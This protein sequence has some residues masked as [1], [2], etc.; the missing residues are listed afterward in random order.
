MNH[1]LWVAVVG[2]DSV[3]KFE[4]SLWQGYG[5]CHLFVQKVDFCPNRSCMGVVRLG[6]QIQ[7]DICL[8]PGGILLFLLKTFFTK[9]SSSGLY[10]TSTFHEEFKI[11]LRF[12]LV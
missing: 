5:P 1:V 10:I 4:S 8:V 7:K 6:H 11:E 2:D 3:E 9:R 12:Y